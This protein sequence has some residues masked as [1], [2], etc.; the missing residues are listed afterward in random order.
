M[1]T[2]SLQVSVWVRAAPETVFDQAAD[3]TRHGEWSSDPLRIEAESAGPMGV[4]SRYRSTAQSHGMTF[5][6]GL[7]ISHYER[8]TRFEFGGQD[9]TAN[10][11]HVFCFEPVEG[12]TRVSRQMILRL[13]LLQWLAFYFLLLPVRLP[14]ARRTLQ[15]LK[16]IVERDQAP[17]EVPHS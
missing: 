15:R 16:E 12:G 17:L 13:S 4:G 6:S 5:T 8:P 9:A 3:L 11:R 1:P 2:A 7:V 14:S 10:F